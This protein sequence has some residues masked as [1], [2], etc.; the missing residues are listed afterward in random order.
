[1]TYRPR[2]SVTTI[3]ANLVGRSVVSAITQTP[4]SGPFGPLTTPPRS[5]SP[6][7]TPAGAVCCAA[8]C[9]GE[10]VSNSAAPIAAPPKCRLAFGLIDG[11][12]FGLVSQRPRAMCDPAQE[13]MSRTQTSALAHIHAQSVIARNGVGARREPPDRFFGHA[14]AR[15]SAGLLRMERGEVGRRRQQIISAEIGHYSGHERS[16]KAIPVAVLHVIELPRGIARR[17]AGDR[18]NWAQSAQIRAVA[19][20]A[21]RDFGPSSRN[22]SND[23]GLAFLQAAWRYIGDET[24][25]WVSQKLGRVRAL[26][27]LDDALA[28][29]LN[30][31]FG[32][33]KRQEH[34]VLSFGLRHGRTLHH[35]DPGRGGNCRKVFG[36]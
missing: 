10:R 16:P 1:M 36:S 6:T 9:A 27:G 7:V 31:G 2:S 5:L 22:S 8:S 28:N 12:S 20:G 24:R 17:A 14:S 23:Q 34:P 15:A 33:L 3:F 32:T 11:S 4:A 19:N 25:S 30:V 13:L 26:R 21:R 35:L 18:W 29:R